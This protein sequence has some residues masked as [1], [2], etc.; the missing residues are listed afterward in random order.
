MILYEF[1]FSLW[2][3]KMNFVCLFYQQHPPFDILLSAN[4]GDI[5]TKASSSAT[6]HC[7]YEVTLF[8]FIIW[9]WS[10]DKDQFMEKYIICFQIW[11]I[12]YVHHL[13]IGT[14]GLLWGFFFPNTNSRVLLQKRN[15]KGPLIY[16][17]LWLWSC[18]I[19]GNIIWHESHDGI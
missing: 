6:I 8:Y 15:K 4:K 18:V 19:H 9:C 1:I 2:N 10:M 7:F 3:I 13:R 5:K 17:L 12:W 14:D 16:F 11:I